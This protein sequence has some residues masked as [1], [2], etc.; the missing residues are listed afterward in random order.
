MK[1]SQSW[2]GTLQSTHLSF[3][4]PLQH[5][6]PTT[7]VFLTLSQTQRLLSPAIMPMY[8]SVDIDRAAYF[9]INDQNVLILLYMTYCKD[10]DCY[11]F[12]TIPL[13]CCLLIRNSGTQLC[14]EE[15]QS[16]SPVSV[17]FFLLNTSGIS[18]AVADIQRVGLSDM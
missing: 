3:K 7:S 2:C 1:T 9:C 4:Q 13:H 5:F 15:N 10:K 12:A 14:K 17:F 18:V 8:I 11:G 16:I 6:G